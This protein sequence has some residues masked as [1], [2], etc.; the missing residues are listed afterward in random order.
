MR[1]H[2]NIGLGFKDKHIQ[3]S[4]FDPQAHRQFLT[5]FLTG[6]FHGSFAKSM[7]FMYNPKTGDKRNYGSLVSLTKKSR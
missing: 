5:T 3:E 2:D 6:D 4:S 1:C 7:P